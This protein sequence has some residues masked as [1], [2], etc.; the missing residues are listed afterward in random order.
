M[1]RRRTLTIIR[2]GLAVLGVCLG[3]T[4]GD[5]FASLTFT[6]QGRFFAADGTTPLTDTADITFSIYNPAGTCLL[7]QEV[8]SS[9]D[10]ALMNGVVSISIG[11]GTRTGSDP[12]LAMEAVLSNRPG[13]LR[14]SG[15]NCAPGYAPA[16][17]DGR[18]VK[19]HV[20]IVSRG[21]STDLTPSLTLDAVPAA[22]EAQ[23]LQGYQA[24][25]FIRSLSS[26]NQA[27]LTTLTDGSNADALHHHDAYV[28]VGTGNSSFSMLSGST[29]GLGQIAAS[30][31]PTLGT[32]ATGSIWF[33]STTHEVRYYDG[34]A[35]LTLLGGDSTSA[36][37][38]FVRRDGSGNFTANLITADLA[39]NATTATTATSATDFSG[40]LTGDVRGSQNSTAV[41]SVSG[42]SASRIA[43]G[44]N[45]VSAAT[46]VSGVNTLVLRDSSGGFSAGG[47]ITAAAFV[48]AFS[49]GATLTGNVAMPGSGMWDSFGNI[50]IG[51]SSPTSAKL[52]IAGPSGQNGID[53]SST[54]QYLDARVI[55]NTHSDH[56]LF[57]G[58]QSGAT[59][60]I[61]LYSNDSETLTVK[62]GN[63]GIGPGAT[64]PA[65]RLQVDNGNI[66]VQ[67][68]ANIPDNG[69]G[70]GFVANH[71]N[72]QMSQIKGVVTNAT[73]VNTG[74]GEDQ[75]GIAFLTRPTGPTGQTLV[76][77][78][79]ID[80][81]GKVGIGTGSPSSALHVAGIVTAS[82]FSGPFS[83]TSGSFTSGITVTGATLTASSGASI[84]GGLNNNS[85]GITN[86]G[87]ISGITSLAGS[88]NISFS[89]SGSSQMV[90][91]ST[92]NVGMGTSS[93]I[94]R[95]QV[96]GALT[97]SSQVS[98]GFPGAIQ[99]IETQSTP[100][101]SRLTFGTDGS[102]YDFTI[103]KNQGGTVSDLFTVR[104]NG[105]VGI[106]TL[107]PEGALHIVSPYMY[108]TDCGTESSTC[109]PAVGNGF[110]LVYD[111]FY[112][113]GNYRWRMMSVDRGS[114]IS[115]Y[116]QEAFGGT[117][118]NVARFGNNA[119][120]S[121]QFAV[122]GNTSLGGSV[123]VGTTVPVGMLNV[124]GASGAAQGIQIDNKEIK[125]RG[126]G[127]AH[128]S[129]FANRIPGAL[130]IDDTSGSLSMG[131]SGVL[132]NLLTLVK[133]NSGTG[134]VGIGTTAPSSALHVMGVVTATSGF[135]G[136]VSGTS[137]SFSDGLSV[138]G[139][140]RA[141][142]QLLVGGSNSVNG[143]F[144]GLP[145]AMNDGSRALW[146]GDYNNAALSDYGVIYGQQLGTDLYRLSIMTGDNAGGGSA[147]DELFLGN[148]NIS[149]SPK[150][151]LIKNGNVGIGTSTPTSPLEVWGGTSGAGNSNVILFDFPGSGTLGDMT[152]S[153]STSWKVQESTYIASRLDFGLHNTA[154]RTSPF[155]AFRTGTE[156]GFP[157][158]GD[159]T[160]ER[161]RIDSYGNVGIGTTTPGQLVEIYSPTDPN[162]GAPQLRISGVANGSGVVGMEFAERNT[163]DVPYAQILLAGVNSGPGVNSGDLAFV[164]ATPGGAGTTSLLSEKMRITATGNVGIGTTNPGTTLDV[165]GAVR[166]G[167]VLAANIGAACSPLGAQGYNATTGA[168]VYCNNSAVW[169]AVGSRPVCTVRTAS[170]GQQATASCNA[171]ETVTGGG[172]NGTGGSNQWL[173]YSIP[174]GNTWFCNYQNNA[175]TVSAYAICCTNM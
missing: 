149:G 15:A 112:T 125:L 118:Y 143:S 170:G 63:I 146:I 21:I 127:D 12:A 164:T 54:D 98:A 6:Y 150:G 68:G 38:S 28:K 40:A 73:S 61:H 89:P 86:V 91:D 82:G 18:L 79:R 113:D 108:Q 78:M 135:S 69:G 156:L 3:L 152:R 168:P 56:D 157:T 114:N 115:F 120:D 145:F 137:G 159:N 67:N 126:D 81:T 71:G 129:I 10:L 50:G 174:S 57:F 138:V 64:D 142:G 9:V 44:V 66:V 70:I 62:N 158:S 103:A 155:I 60:S 165:N 32:A 173:Y 139:S 22:Y 132:G 13:T 74:T 130:T 161:M 100:V 33:N 97:V 151:M 111:S 163:A 106:G 59:S 116:V 75:G 131:P 27:N 123:G 51:T 1:Q 119:Y 169:T 136:P 31:E 39:G 162:N 35:N 101:S 16:A 19:V 80:A 124:V 134:Y 92:G 4:S 175:A 167:S 52:V 34:S 84:S 11:T 8:F 26:V 58:Y 5:A 154:N 55:Q 72:S 43:S 85:N 172:C 141:D 88:G 77:R 49:G 107:Y 121:N 65:S 148:A 41:F 140:L 117:T 14:S 109:P 87:S 83:G 20:D 105:R 30:G 160:V 46:S 48:G 2:N 147:D 23:K 76:E 29:L 110:G 128:Y 171:G 36:T 153:I 45:A 7:E 95:L 122:F 42:V 99:L 94:S 93:P 166:P 104:D 24:S 102:G 25:D 37:N 47:T 96:A 90:I 144:N 133:R 53:L 17:T